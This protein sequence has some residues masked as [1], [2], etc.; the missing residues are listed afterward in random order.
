MT[1]ATQYQSYDS[2]L[3]PAANTIVAYS[4]STQL[5]RWNS[6]LSAATNT[7]STITSGTLKSQYSSADGKDIT[8]V[9]SG[10]SIQSINGQVSGTIVTFDSLIATSADLSRKVTLNG[11][12][13][14]NMVNYAVTGTINSLLF[15]D[16]LTTA[17]PYY[18][19]YKGK[20]NDNGAISGYFDSIDYGYTGIAPN[21]AGT[22][23][24]GLTNAGAGWDY[25][26][27]SY[28]ISPNALVGSVSGVETQ[29]GVIVYQSTY[30]SFTPVSANIFNLF[31]S[32]MSGNDRITLTGD[33]NR[34]GT[35]GFGG[36]DYIKG[37]AGDNWFYNCVETAKLAYSGLGN[38]TIDGGAG[39]DS[40]FFGSNKA[41]GNY[42]FDGFDSIL[43]SVQISDGA[44][45]DNT[46]ND[47]F[48]NIEIFYFSDTT[49]TW[50]QLEQYLITSAAGNTPSFTKTGTAL[51][52]SIS[53]SPFND[54]ID[55]IDGNDS[56]YG[57][58]GN[59]LLYGGAGNDSIAGGY[60]NDVIDGGVGS[61]TISGGDGSD[62]L[63]GGGGSDTISGD[64]GNDY[65]YGQAANDVL[66]G[67]DGADIVSGGD[68]NDTVSGG[69][70]D[71]GMYGDA[72]VD[73]MNGNGGGDFMAGGD[74]NDIQHGDDGQDWI[75]GEWGDDT[76]Y[77]DA[78]ND[79]LFGN[80][81][82]DTLIGG[83][84]NDL[85]YGGEGGDTFVFTANQGEDFIVDF[86]VAQGDHISIASGANGITTAAQALAHV[87]DS[88][89][90]AVVE[91][92]SGSYVM[93][94]GVATSALHVTDFVIG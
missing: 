63:Y 36:N 29:S 53:G 4:S 90:N 3:S 34:F 79:F 67:G 82:N 15:Q 1:N 32:I 41:I 40:V 59:D 54:A 49:L 93:L 78:G 71:D 58:A 21:S 19:L 16:Q 88:G 28:I 60:G 69:N 35:T 91:L 70:G 43:K 47:V 25:V 75:Y 44:A 52:D 84:G 62:W 72:G 57:L 33:G 13:T 92:G 50:S 64:A 22:M 11:I 38:D 45:L 7:V 12:L 6:T 23:K 18:Y 76:V 14:V 46:G 56:I 5:Y 89:A 9:T 8:V 66:D 77:G 26:T 61:D 37:D 20:I 24:Y 68:G 51:G 39:N 42:L 87:R 94:M 10:G 83:L 85:L 31:Y 81:G 80:F 30:E 17:N 48:F 73:T 74:D 86:S 2:I 65:L 27:K 55:G